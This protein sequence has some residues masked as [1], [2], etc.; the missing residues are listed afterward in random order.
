[1]KIIDENFIPDRISAICKARNVKVKDLASLVGLP[2]ST[3]HNYASGRSEPK[4]EFFVALYSF[5]IDF[6]WFFSDAGPMFRDGEHSPQ[7]QA[8]N[9]LLAQWVD[10][11][12]A[13]HTK[14]EI[15]WLEVEVAKRFPAFNE[16]L[17]ANGHEPIAKQDWLD[18]MLSSQILSL[19]PDQQRKISALLDEFDKENSAQKP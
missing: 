17:V 15:Y 16:W 10:E 1:M 3:L 12:M 18:R 2:Y 13:T 5:G 4:L 7:A 14:H 8:Q 9:S 6:D 19:P 11:Y